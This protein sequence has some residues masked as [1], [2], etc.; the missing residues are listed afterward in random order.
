V[1]NHHGKTAQLTR[2]KPALNETEKYRPDIDGI[3]AIA[4]LSVVIYHAGFKALGG[5][6]A[7]V[8]VFFVI[9]GYLI[10]R[11]IA[12]RLHGNQLSLVEFY[13]R[14]IRRIIPALFFLLL[15]AVAASFFTLLPA[16][17]YRF[18]KNVVATV[19]FVP[20]V[21]FWREAGYFGLSGGIRTIPL[22]RTVG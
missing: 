15:F 7:G 16:D 8:D 4:G 5:G 1:R 21:M 9:S 17:L 18:A 2:G 20:N 13:E 6:Y 3:R 11:Y 10:T 14:R 19:L 12:Q 22:I